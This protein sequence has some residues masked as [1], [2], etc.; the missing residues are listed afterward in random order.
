MSGT[1]LHRK[2]LM[3]LRLGLAPDRAWFLT[4]ILL[5]ITAWWVIAGL[6]YIAIPGSAE[7]QSDL[8]QTYIGWVTER[9]IGF[10]CCLL[11]VGLLHMLKESEEGSLV[12]Q[13]PAYWQR[14]RA[15]ILH[16]AAMLTLAML[17]FASFMV[18]Y[19]TIKVRIPEIVPFVWDD[20]FAA[21]DEALFLGVAPWRLFEWVYHVPYLLRGLDLIYDFWMAALVGSWAFC[22]IYRGGDTARQLRY[23]LALMLTWFVGGNVLAIALSSAGPCYFDHVSLAQPDYYV[24]QMTRL[25]EAGNI[26][27]LQTQDMLWQSYRGGSLGVGGISAMPSM[28]CATSFLF[29]LMFG[30]TTLTRWLTGIYFLI[31]LF[32]SVILAWHYLVDG[33]LGA[34]VAWACWWACGRLPM[35]TKAM[36][37]AKS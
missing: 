27:A 11:V 24:P 10:A 29:A 3:A 1:S 34:A 23:C 14:H 36:F 32:T 9:G 28:H 16:A 18:A 26:N 35:I 12:K 37:P 15:S 22:F 5:F 7:T 21:M 17:A 25:M 30:R 2:R 31:I 13:I 6:F 33:L 8:A 19:T 20:T 4:P